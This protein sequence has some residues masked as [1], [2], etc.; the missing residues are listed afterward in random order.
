MKK[1]LIALTAITLFS[2]AHAQKKGPGF[3]VKAGANFYSIG[4]GDAD[5]FGLDEKRKTKVGLVGGILVNIPFTSTF[6]VQ[7]ELLY[8]EEGN[9]QKDGDV[10]QKYALTFLNLPIMLQYNTPSGF[11]VE[12]G[13]QIGYTLS[14]K[15]KTDNGLDKEEIDLK[16]GIKNIGFSWGLGAGFKCKS[17]F[18]IGARYNR[19]LSSLDDTEDNAKITS[20]GFHVGV[21]ISLAGS[22]K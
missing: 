12:T 14:A 18:G 11:Y 7:P 9:L 5:D 15:L 21:F 16:D 10:S 2:T 17:G 20:N 19:G 22:K 1:L 8:S 13:P 4:G 6:S 3:G